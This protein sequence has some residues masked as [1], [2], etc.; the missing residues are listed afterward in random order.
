MLQVPIDACQNRLPFQPLAFLR[1]V[2]RVGSGHGT[3]RSGLN[4]P[5]P[6]LLRQRNA[7]ESPSLFKPRG[8]E[9]REDYRAQLR[10]LLRQLSSDDALMVTRLDRLAR[11][12]HDR[13]ADSDRSALHGL[14]PPRHTGG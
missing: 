3:N 12:D 11:S 10:R 4:D 13:K 1:A 8:G 5:F 14:T 2:Q 7:S 9:R 6:T